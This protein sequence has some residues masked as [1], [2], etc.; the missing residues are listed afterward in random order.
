MPERRLIHIENTKFIYLTNFSGDPSRDRFGS[1]ARKANIIIPDIMQARQLIDEEFNI[2]MTSP[3]PGE[4]EG[5]VPEYFTTIKVNYNTSWP[6]KIYLISGSAEPRLL[7]EETIGELDMC[8]IRNVDVTLNPY[9][10]PNASKGSFYV[11]TMY[12]TQ[13]LEDDPFANKYWSNDDEP[14]FDY[15]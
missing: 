6:P 9:R 1:N 8:R 13:D 15:E 3:R 7:D 11:R 10:S 4:E 5:F 2:R 14:P 12:V